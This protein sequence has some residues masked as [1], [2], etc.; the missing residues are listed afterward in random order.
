MRL[1]PI[2]MSHVAPELAAIVLFWGGVILFGC[3][4]LLL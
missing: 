2:H 4:L 1:D 3:L